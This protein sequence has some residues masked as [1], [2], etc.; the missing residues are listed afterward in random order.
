MRRFISL[1]IIVLFFIWII[2]LGVFITPDKEKKTCNGQR[3]ICLC[4][5]LIAKKMAKMAGK[6]Y[7]TS[8]G[9]NKEQGSS[10]ASHDFLIA[11]FKNQINK[12]ISPH[13]QKATVVCN[14]LIVKPIEHVPKT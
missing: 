6:M 11:L 2:P 3:A 8:G 7:L 12:N 9:V 4:S 1:L 5:H 13:F 14:R 10:S